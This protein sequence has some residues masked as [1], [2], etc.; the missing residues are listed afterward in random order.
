MSK[1]KDDVEFQDIL[2][3]VN[4]CVKDDNIEFLSNILFV[5][6]Q[7]YNE[8]AKLCTDGNYHRGWSHTKVLDYITYE[9]H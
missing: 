3:L 7:N 8:L 1:D 4:Q 2:N 9:S 6:Q 5:L